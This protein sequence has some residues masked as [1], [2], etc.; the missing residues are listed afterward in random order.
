MLFLIFI[1]LF[2]FESSIMDTFSNYATPIIFLIG[3]YVLITGKKRNIG[4]EMNKIYK[5]WILLLVWFIILPIVDGRIDFN[6]LLFFQGMFHDYRYLIFA[7]LPF[8]FISDYSKF[9]YDKFFQNVGYVALLAGCFG[10]LIADKSLL[11]VSLRGD[12]FSLPYY[13]WWVVLM[14]FPYLFLVF[15]HNK[16]Q[17]IGL[18]LIVLHFLFSLLFL[19]R[20]GF[21]N[22]ILVILLALIFSNNRSNRTVY[23]IIFLLFSFLSFFFFEDY[24]NL[25]FGRFSDTYSDFSSW[26]RNTEFQ[27]FLEN[28]TISKLLTGFGANNYITMYYIG[29]EDNS[30]NALHIGAYNL[31]YKGGALYVFFMLYLSK[32]IFSLYKY[33]KYNVEI[34][35]GFILGLIY[36]LSHAYE[37]SWTY[38]PTIFF[39]LLPIYRAIYL[40]DKLRQNSLMMKKQK[41]NG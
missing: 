10:I 21:L 9:Y 18:Y 29:V 16:K 28:I 11:S 4:K 27:E 40:K 20:A 32:K 3:V 39:T 41:N 8:L 14:V 34:K 12:V 31:L 25:I 5:F 38:L 33:I 22:G 30:V 7:T 35:I 1:T 23:T 6:L 2:R 36:I 19:K 26:D 13:M 17:K 24:F 37:Q 15:F